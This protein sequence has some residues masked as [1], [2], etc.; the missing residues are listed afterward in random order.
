MA[1]TIYNA[2]YENLYWPYPIIAGVSSWYLNKCVDSVTS[3]WVYWRTQYQDFTGEEYPG[4][5][6]SSGTYKV[7][8][9]KFGS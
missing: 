7:Q 3:Q 8:A 9:I 6:F 4:S 5:G 2:G 1:V